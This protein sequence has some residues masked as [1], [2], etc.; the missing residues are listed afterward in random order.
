MSE[1]SF[2]TVIKNPGFNN[3]W[4]NQILVQLAYNSLNFA[5]IIWVFRLTN[6]TTAVSILLLCVYSPAVVLGLF[7][8]VLVD[9][10]DR[11]KI[12]LFVDFFL[13]ILFLSL[14]FLKGSFPAL[15]LIAFLVNSLAQFYTPAESSSIPLLVKKDQLLKANSLFS[16]TLFLTFLFGFGLS[17][18]IIA[19]GGIN[20]VFLIGTTSLFLAFILAI[21]FPPIRSKVTAES[22]QLLISFEKRNLSEARALIFAEAK[23]VLRE[24]KGKP[25]VLS[26]IFILAGV[27]AIVGILGV[28]SPSFLERVLQISATDAS[29]VLIAP[30]GTGTILGAMLVGRVG[31][32]Y[33]RRVLV[34]K[35]ISVAGAL[36]FLVGGA[37]LI[38]PAIRYFPRHHPL[39]FFYQPSLSTVLIIG[40]FLLGLTLAFIIVPSQTVLQENSREQDRGKIFSVLAVAMS[41]FSIL[42]VLFV[43][44]LADI[45]G[46]LPIFI[47][48]GGLIALLGL[49]I[50]KPD[51]F[52]APHHLPRHIKE[53]LGLGHWEK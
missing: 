4:I 51:F 52:F 13:A 17:G 6:S 29:Y 18:P 48:L 40:S 43:G 5:L 7:A 49:F 20:A 10:L 11:K 14:I 36:L 21:R 47:G 39:P 3:L 8:G 22:K 1:S 30:L 33:P 27:Q 19:I 42:P 16:S 9:A 41:A 38:S 23:K 26:A 25:L 35:A 15:L 53:L 46:T 50:L 24:I 32:L 12:F 2:G 45:F 37:P 31:N 44:I 28:L 34:G